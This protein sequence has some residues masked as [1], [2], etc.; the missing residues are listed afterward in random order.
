MVTECPTRNWWA[1]AVKNVAVD[2]SV[3]S[4]GN[5][6]KSA[7]ET[8]AARPLAPALKVSQG[9]S[10]VP[11]LQLAGGVGGPLPVTVATG[12]TAGAEE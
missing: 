4:S 9:H 10:W 5:C 8:A 7:E 1:A 2:G 12:G 6:V 11:L 3:V